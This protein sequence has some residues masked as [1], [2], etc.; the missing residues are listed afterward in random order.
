MNNIVLI[1]R[2]EHVWTVFFADGTTVVVVRLARY[3]VGNT[4]VVSVSIQCRTIHLG[5]SGD[6]IGL[7]VIV[8]VTSHHDTGYCSTEQDAS[9]G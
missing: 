1:E 7:T 2:K 3:L 9:E 4:P 8:M 5:E 6:A